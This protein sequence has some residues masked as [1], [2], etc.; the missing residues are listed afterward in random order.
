MPQRQ[1]LLIAWPST[2]LLLQDLTNL[3]G[4]RLVNVSTHRSPR[5]SLNRR[6]YN[7]HRPQVGVFTRQSIDPGHPLPSGVLCSGQLRKLGVQLKCLRYL[8]LEYCTISPPVTT[9]DTSTATAAA[10]SAAAATAADDPAYTP[11]RWWEIAGMPA[12]F[13]SIIRKLDPQGRLPARWGMEGAVKFIVDSQR[14]AAQKQ[15]ELEEAERRK[16]EQKDKWQQEAYERQ[17]QAREIAKQR[18]QREQEKH[19]RQHAEQQAE[20]EQQMQQHRAQMQRRE[21]YPPPSHWE[22]AEFE[23]Q[24]AQW[25]GQKRRWDEEMRIWK[26]ERAGW[27]ADRECWEQED[28]FNALRISQSHRPFASAGKSKKNSMPEDGVDAHLTW[29]GAA[30]AAAAALPKPPKEVRVVQR[31]QLPFTAF[32]ELRLLSLRSSSILGYPGNKVW[33]PFIPSLTALKSLRFLDL[34]G[35]EPDPSELYE[36]GKRLDQLHWLSVSA[37]AYGTP[38]NIKKFLLETQPTFS[39]LEGSSF[40][41][42][43]MAELGVVGGLGERVAPGVATIGSFG[44]FEAT[45]SGNLLAQCCCPSCRSTRSLY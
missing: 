38:D 13:N 19:N 30:A 20:H 22:E 37:G 1:S 44:G 8:L 21:Q 26:V 10:G 23:R 3:Q 6:S 40:L 41:E 45:A 36:A 11:M 28:H 32:P 9:G 4:L 33:Q 2:S 27:A 15:A 43:V 29:V 18:H 7:P 42:V 16:Q 5:V 25:A 17:L 14:A 35:L 24:R 39:V 34:T 12:S 31:Q